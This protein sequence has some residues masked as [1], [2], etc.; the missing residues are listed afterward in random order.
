MKRE[1]QMHTLHKF[2]QGVTKKN[3]NSLKSFLVTIKCEH[4]IKEKIAL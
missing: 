2:R 1:R 4:R 3:G